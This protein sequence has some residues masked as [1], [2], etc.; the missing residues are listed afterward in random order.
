MLGGDERH[1][2]LIS[3]TKVDNTPAEVPRKYRFQDMSNAGDVTVNSAF[4]FGDI[5]GDGLLDVVAGSTIASTFRVPSLYLNKGTPTTPLWKLP[6]SSEL[7]IVAP[8]PTTVELRP[9]VVDIDHDDIADILAVDEYGWQQAWQL[10]ET[11]AGLKYVTNSVMVGRF[12]SLPK[13]LDMSMVAIDLDGACNGLRKTVSTVM[14]SSH[15]VLVDGVALFAAGDSDKDLLI[16]SM[17]HVYP[18]SNGAVE[19]HPQCSGHGVCISTSELATVAQVCFT[20]WLRCCLACSGITPLLLCL[21]VA[22]VVHLG[23]GVGFETAPYMCVRVSVHRR[24]VR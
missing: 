7:Q 8:A 24:G 13:D 1:V 23:R 14:A 5:N 20:W 21:F 22:V 19:C 11:V 16:G 9:L 6:V 2:Y 17:T 12:S 18:A 3:N 15:V 4:A 10:A